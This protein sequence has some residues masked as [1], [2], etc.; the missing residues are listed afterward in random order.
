MASF[1]WLSVGTSTAPLFFYLVPKRTLDILIT[2]DLQ[3]SKVKKSKVKNIKA[4]RTITYRKVEVKV[5]TQ[6]RHVL[7][8][9]MLT[10]SQWKLQ[11][12]RVTTMSTHTKAQLTQVSTQWLLWTLCT[13]LQWNSVWIT[14]CCIFQPFTVLCSLFVFFFKLRVESGLGVYILES[15]RCSYYCWV[16]TSI[17][18]LKHLTG[19]N[20]MTIQWLTPQYSCFSAIFQ[21]YQLVPVW[22]K[23]HLHLW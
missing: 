4:S 18:G 21:F 5:L 19:S 3:I 1:W 12:P 13:H 16:I 10:G 7:L 11:C 20:A 22:L 9:V 6:K 2:L 14:M 8:L 23:R 15:K 17:F